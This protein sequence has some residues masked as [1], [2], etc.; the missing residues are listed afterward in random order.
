MSV[1]YKL[2]DAIATRGMCMSYYDEDEYGGEK[3]ELRLEYG[4]EY[5]PRMGNVIWDC[6]RGVD[7]FVYDC[8]VRNSPCLR[9]MFDDCGSPELVSY[10]LDLLLDYIECTHDGYE[11]GYVTERGWSTPP[12]Y[13]YSDPAAAYDADG[14]ITSAV[15]TLEDG[16][17]G[18]I[19]DDV[20]YALYEMAGD[21]VREA[22]LEDTI[23]KV[24]AVRTD[25]PE[26]FGEVLAKVAES[27][28]E[29]VAGALYSSLDGEDVL[30]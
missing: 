5:C 17:D 13:N 2:G 7:S 26:G 10:V 25:A 16:M 15:V 30:D 3:Y 11:I 21:E 28:A 19:Y 22:S 20:M 23:R 4:K 6:C 27:F 24:V 12:H 29:K 18:Y 14:E 9:S 8:V 1:T